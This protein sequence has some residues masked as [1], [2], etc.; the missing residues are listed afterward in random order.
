VLIELGVVRQEA[1]RRRLGGA[2]VGVAR[3]RAGA[4]R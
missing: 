2:V 3:A 4:R 1:H